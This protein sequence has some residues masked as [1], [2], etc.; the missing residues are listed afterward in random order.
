M[1]SSEPSGTLPHIPFTEDAD[2]TD[3]PAAPPAWRGWIHLGTFPVALVLGIVLVV[4]AASPA[5]KASSAVFMATSL[6]LFGVSATYHRFPWGSKV[7][8]VLKRIDHTNIFLL[9]AGTYT[10]IAVCAL[11]TTPATVLLVLMWSGAL[12]GIAF[13]VFWIGAPRWLYVP[14]YVLLGCAALAFLPQLFAANVA[15]MTLELAGGLAYVVGAVV[16]GFKRP[17]PA[18]GV[19]GFHE[20][21]HALT[22]VAF[23]AQWVGILVIA[24]QPVR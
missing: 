20:V 6:V 7:K 18:P 11:A 23:L 3:Q 17:N 10:P 22:V 14:L 21:F 24:L 19:F 2:A 15:M 12:L 9:I 5:A 8:R 13:R 1:T 4:L 16:Y